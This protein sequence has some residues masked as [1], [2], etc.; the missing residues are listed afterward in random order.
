MWTM[1]LSEVNEAELIRRVRAG[2]AEAFD[3][4]VIQHTPALFR[5]V[6]RLASDAAEAEAIVQEAFLRAWRNLSRYQND[7]PFFPYLVTIAVNLA[8]DQWRKT[9]HLD[10][11]GL[12]AIEESMADSGPI[13]ES[14]IERT[15][16]LQI[17]AQAVA[18][19]PPAYRT[20]IALRY[21]AGL[22][23]QQ[24]ADT[25]ELPV[26]TV[27]THLRRAKLQL[28]KDLEL[29]EVLDG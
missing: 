23:Y 8:R 10:F 19:L 5:V 16:T 11:G 27:R 29:Q 28:R 18:D 24:I 12:E 6:R 15:E 25:L 1:S 9:R 13:P 2:D 20:V 4:L 21:D 22:S 26:N 14:V 3:Q 7:R 17:L